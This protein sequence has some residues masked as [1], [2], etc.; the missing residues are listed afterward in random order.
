MKAFSELFKEHANRI[1]S[2]SKLSQI[3]LEGLSQLSKAPASKF[4]PLFQFMAEHIPAHHQN[5]PKINMPEY[6]VIGFLDGLTL[7]ATVSEVEAYFH[8]LILAV[9]TKHPEKIGKSAVDLRSILGL[10][11]IEDIKLLVAER[12]AS[13]MLFKKPSD[14]KKD[15]MTIVSAEDHLFDA[16]WPIFVEAKAR[17]DIGVHNSWIAN[18]IY[19]AKVREV[20]LTP[21]TE[22]TLSVD[23]PY[24]Q[25]VQANCI[26]LMKALKTHCETTFA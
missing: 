11:S 24:L 19:R 10:T 12:Y 2:L 18:D 23:R 14:Y 13:E 4:A 6:R 21:T 7:I 3:A 8:D 20:G 1:L 15:L 22:K 25:T 16:T 9:L 26:D 5:H 17:R